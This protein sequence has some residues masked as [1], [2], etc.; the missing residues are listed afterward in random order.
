MGYDSFHNLLLKVRKFFDDRYLIEVGETNHTITSICEMNPSDLLV[1]KK[2]GM[3]YGL[4]QS[5]LKW[6]QYLLHK[7]EYNSGLYMVSTS[8]HKGELNEVHSKIYPVFEF[9]KYGTFD[10]LLELL[11]EFCNEILNIQKKDIVYIYPENI[12]ILDKTQCYSHFKDIKC[13]ITTGLDSAFNKFFWT[14]DNMN[15]RQ[16]KV[17]AIILYGHVVLLGGERH[18]NN[19]KMM[20]DVYTLNKGQYVNTL[21]NL[22]SKQRVEDELSLYANVKL[23]SRF[24][25]SIHLNLLENFIEIENQTDSI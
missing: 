6:I 23:I 25:A 19:Q 2:N 8:Y 20:Y 17:T 16:Y 15:E 14:Y 18:N 13:V 22:F 9:A 24:G 21:Y 10:D 3:I 1:C 4:P 11:V 7:N 5:N 12:N